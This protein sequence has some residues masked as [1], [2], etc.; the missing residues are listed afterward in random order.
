LLSVGIAVGEKITVVTVRMLGLF[1][2]QVT[3]HYYSIIILDINYIVLKK[4][5]IMPRA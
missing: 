4:I 5:E 3:N 1:V 2:N